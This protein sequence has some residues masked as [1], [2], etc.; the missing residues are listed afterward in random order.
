MRIFSALALTLFLTACASGGGHV[1]CDPSDPFESCGP[2][3][4]HSN[5]SGAASTPSKGGGHSGGGHGNGHGK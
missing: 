3:E 2:H 5:N 4:Q 1:A